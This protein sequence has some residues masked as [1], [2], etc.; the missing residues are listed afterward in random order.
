MT[1]E[2]LA[3]N[4]KEPRGHRQIYQVGTLQLLA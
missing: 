1:I 2:D 3:P 4:R